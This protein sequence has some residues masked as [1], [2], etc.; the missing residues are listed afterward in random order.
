MDF[1]KVGSAFIDAAE[2]GGGYISKKQFDECIRTLIPGGSLDKDQRKSLSST[3][4]ALFYAFDRERSDS[5]DAVELASG[6][7]IF[8][9]G[10]KSDK[11][12]YAWE[13]VDEDLDGMLSRRGT[14]R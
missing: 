2:E 1:R 7:S 8:C 5:V 10:S 6:F 13:I 11:L 9:K 4:S 3:L 14:W 12:S